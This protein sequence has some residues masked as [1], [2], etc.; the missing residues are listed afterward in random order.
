MFCDCENVTE[1]RA[2]KHFLITV[3][4]V[5]THILQR[6]VMLQIQQLN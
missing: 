6:N 1:V 4:F 5:F 2:D 3:S